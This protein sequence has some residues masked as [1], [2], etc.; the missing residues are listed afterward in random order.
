MEQRTGSARVGVGP[1]SRDFLGKT[2]FPILAATM[3]YRASGLCVRAFW[4]R[5][6]AKMKQPLESI[7]VGV[8][9]VIT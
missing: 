9:H 7:D 6:H 5:G 8:G 2:N 1:K 3:M 4:T